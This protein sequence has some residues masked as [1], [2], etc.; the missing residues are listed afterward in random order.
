MMPQMTTPTNTEVKVLEPASS[1]DAIAKPR[2]IL[3][4]TSEVDL[5][6]DGESMARKLLKEILIQGALPGTIEGLLLWWDKEMLSSKERKIWRGI[7]LVVLWSL[8]KLRND[9]VFNASVP[10][11][12]E[13]CEVIKVRIALWW[14]PFYSEHSF[15]IQDFVHNLRASE[16]VYCRKKGVR[17]LN[18]IL[19][20]CCCV[21]SSFY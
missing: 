13:L 7:P 16:K 17:C 18:C 5:L 10:N 3:Q 14:R 6:D 9:V 15:T 4:T 8:W 2:I 1:N 12:A 11:V 20:L 19:C 21:L